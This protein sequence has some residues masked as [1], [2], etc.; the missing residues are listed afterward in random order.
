VPWLDPTDIAERQVRELALAVPPAAD[1]RTVHRWAAFRSEEDLQRDLGFR[2]GW[3]RLPHQGEWHG[4]PI[5]KDLLPDGLLARAGF[6]PKD[7]LLEGF[8]WRTR[9]LKAR[10]KEPITGKVAPWMEPQPIHERIRRQL[11]ISVPAS[12]ISL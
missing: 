11:A 6:Q 1:E 8:S 5:V 7:I 10:G 4:W 9:W 3:E 2:Q 12:V